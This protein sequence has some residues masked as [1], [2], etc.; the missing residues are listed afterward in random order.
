MKLGSTSFVVV[1]IA[2]EAFISASASSSP[3][4][5]NALHHRGL[6]NKV[7]RAVG[8][9]EDANKVEARSALEKRKAYSGTATLYV[10]DLSEG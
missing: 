10:D 2:A 3:L 6:L 8:A 5:N 1:A 9:R 7:K 4:S